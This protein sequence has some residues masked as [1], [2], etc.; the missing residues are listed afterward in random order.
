MEKENPFFFICFVFRFLFFRNRKSIT[1]ETRQV[2]LRFRSLKAKWL[3]R[4]KGSTKQ[5]QQQEKKKK[6]IKRGT[7]AFMWKGKVVGFQVF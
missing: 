4:T 5:S 2:L 3:M 1:F 6:E 7:L